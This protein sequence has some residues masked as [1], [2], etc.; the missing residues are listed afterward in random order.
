MQSRKDET[1]EHLKKID[2]LPIDT[3][4]GIMAGAALSDIAITLALI[5]DQL[6]EIVELFAKNNGEKH[7]ESR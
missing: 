5:Y 4:K 7:E 2:E 3:S 1:V 6:H